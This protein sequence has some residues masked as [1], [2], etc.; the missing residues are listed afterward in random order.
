MG[1][2]QL[3]HGA[4]VEGGGEKEGRELGHNGG[5]GWGQEAQAPQ[6]GSQG[7]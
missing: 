6:G 5:P 1:L 2:R 7:E 3:C 4:V